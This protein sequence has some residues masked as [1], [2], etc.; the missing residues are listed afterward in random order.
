MLPVLAVLLAL[1]TWQVQRLAWK[2]AI[3]ERLDAAAAAPPVPLGDAPEPYTRVTTNGRFDFT[4]EAMLGLEVRGTVLGG[5]LLTPLLREGQPPLLVNRGWVPLQ[6]DEAVE[7]PEGEVTITGYIRPPDAANS[8][9][10]RDDVAGRRFY[11]F[12]PA[13][14]ARGLDLPPPL[15]FALVVLGT[16]QPNQLPAPATTLPRPD[17]PHLGYALTWYGLAATLVGVFG[18]FFWRQRKGT[19]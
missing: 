15:P 6:R 5:N 8:L 10:A 19:A 18:A 1:G 12:D 11:S 17:N 3:L 4:R 9:A 16:P 13:A 7:R 14:I 2:T